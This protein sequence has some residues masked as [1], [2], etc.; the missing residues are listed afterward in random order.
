VNPNKPTTPAPIDFKK[1]E[2]TLL[3][4]KN[5]LIEVIESIIR[6]LRETP[7]SM[8]QLV[9]KQDFP[10]LSTTTHKL[11][12]S[13]GYLGNPYLTDLLSNMMHQAEQKP[14]AQQLGEGVEE[15]IRHAKAY[16]PSL[17]SYLNELKNR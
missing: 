1:L 8:R 2:D 9:Q 3:N 16:L 11:K 7:F 4:K 5:D 15:V 6:A 10:T 12:S 17:L 14:N 13:V